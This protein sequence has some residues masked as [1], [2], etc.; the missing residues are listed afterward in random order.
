MIDWPESLV[1]ELA[2]RRCVIVLGAGASAGC[3][4]A[5]GSRN[6]PTWRELLESFIQRIASAGDAD[7]ARQFVNSEKYLHAA[8]VIRD[9]IPAADFDQLVRREFQEPRY[10]FGRIHELINKLDPKVVVTTNY[11]DIYETYSSRGE[12][13]NGYNVCNYYDTHALNDIRSTTRSILKAHGSVS[14]PSRI[15]LSLADYFKARRDYPAFFAVLDAC[16]LTNTLLFIGCGLN[17]PDIGLLLE[18]V[19]ISA[20]STHPHYAVV[21]SVRHESIKRAFRETYNLQLLE[22]PA[23]QHHEV[24]GSLEELFESVEEYRNTH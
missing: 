7:E 1:P 6:P 15:V 20:P 2:E 10:Q 16:F 5:D 19:N 3:P 23:G 24:V 14:D 9:A 4:S 22:Y 12:A 21:E 8:Q 17:D 11:D 18:N 13:V